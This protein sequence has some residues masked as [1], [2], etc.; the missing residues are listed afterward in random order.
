MFVETAKS[1]SLRLISWIGWVKVG[2]RELYR[3]ATEEVPYHPDDSTAAEGSKTKSKRGQK[4][5]IFGHENQ[6]DNG[7]SRKL[8][9]NCSWFSAEP[10]LL[11]ARHFAQRQ[12][13]LSPPDK[14]QAA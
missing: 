12:S 4:A 8:T 3:R 10:W 7:F 1:A 9:T 11:P 2:K 14:D 13:G 5:T 6:G